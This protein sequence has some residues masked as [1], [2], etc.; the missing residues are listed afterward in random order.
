MAGPALAKLSL[1]RSGSI[2]KEA[3]V[4]KKKKNLVDEVDK[5]RISLKRIESIPE[6]EGP[7]KPTAY[8]ET[9]VRLENDWRSSRHGQG[10][11]LL[12]RKSQ[13]FDPHRE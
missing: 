8:A 7:Q 4:T 11:Y 10:G 1:V 3:L 6:H 13:N 12:A 2:P 9:P 5:H